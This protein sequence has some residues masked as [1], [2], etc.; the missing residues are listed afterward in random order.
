[1]QKQNI[2]NKI[3]S[4]RESN[5][6]NQWYLYMIGSFET[7]R[8]YERDK[9]AEHTVIDKAGDILDCKIPKFLV[10]H[11]ENELL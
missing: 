2:N 8:K 11:K 3:Y 4:D 6:H 9:V 10:S 5:E 1:M 7:H